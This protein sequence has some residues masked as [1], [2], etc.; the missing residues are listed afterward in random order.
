MRAAIIFDIEWETDDED[1]DLPSMIVV[2][3]IP[4]NADDEEV[5]DAIADRLSDVFDWLHHGFTWTYLDQLPS[6]TLPHLPQE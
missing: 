6:M 1:V 5:H 3:A 2:G 4:V